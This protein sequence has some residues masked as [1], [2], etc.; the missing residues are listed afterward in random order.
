MSANQSRRRIETGLSPDSSTRPKIDNTLPYQRGELELNSIRLV[1]IQSAVDDEDPVICSL[2]E[3][4]YGSKPKFEALSYMWGAEKAKDVITVNNHPFEVRRNLLDALLFLRR[5]VASGKARQPFWID[6]ICIKQSDVEERN[7]QV[8][9]MDQIYFRA[10]TVVV[11]L[12]SGYTEFQKELVG[13]V[14]PDGGKERE[15][16]SPQSENSIQ[17]KMVRL[18]RTDPYWDRLWILQEIGRALKL[19]VCFG[20]KSS[21]WQNFM[22][23]IAMHNSDGNTGPLRLDR[24]LR[25]EKYNDSHTLKRLLEE[26]R[27]A[28]CSEPRDK[29]YGLVGLATDA[30]G[31][32][33]DYSKSLYDVWKDTMV[34]MNQRGLFEHESQILLIGGLVKRSLMGNDANPFTQIL[35]DHEDQVEPNQLIE[36]EKSALVFCLK[37]IPL[38]CVIHVGPSASD[39]ISKP[40]EASDWRIATQRLFPAKQLGSAHREHDSLL[41]ALLESDESDIEMT[42]FHRPSTVVWKEPRRQNGSAKGYI[43]E[44]QGTIGTTVFELPQM[45]QQATDR[46]APVQP[47]LYL[48][49]RNDDPTPRKMG[50][51]S[52]LV[53]PGDLVCWVRSTK[54]AILVRIIGE[55][56]GCAKAR[57]FGTALATEDICVSAPDQDYAQRWQSLKGEWR[58]TVQ[59]DAGTVF[60]LLE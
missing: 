28:K 59:V 56:Q 1:E 10:R 21:S 23:Y 50:V 34:F 58:M 26:H 41:R 6:A 46:L 33:M 43:A 51:A 29:V 25:Q 12:G 54:R 39:I 11:W 5:Q 24:L 17:Q 13:E 4:T 31:F 42:C 37:A 52:G 22:Q 32:T 57:V 16:N 49:K 35:R 55:D 30:T 48:A 14:K 27:E 36:D 53:R 2:S 15:G 9:I 3:V 40:N 19:R 47:R 45:S 7:R 20:E 8:R 60:M 38:G 44:V 18:L